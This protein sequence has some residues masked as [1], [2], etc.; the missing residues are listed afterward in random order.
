MP[1]N[2]VRPLIPIFFLLSMGCASAPHSEKGPPIRVAIQLTPLKVEEIPLEQYVLGVLSGEV[3]ADWPVE[4]LKAQA[5]ASRTYAL[6]RKERPKG[7][8]GG[9]MYDVESTVQAQVFD[10][11]RKY[12]PNFENAVEETQGETL[13]YEG[14][15]IPAFFHS[16]CGGI[17]ERADAVWAEEFPPPLNQIHEDPYCKDSPRYRWSYETDPQ[18]LRGEI[19]VLERSETGRVDLLLLTSE[20]EDQELTGNQLREKVGYDKIKSTLF[21]VD[22]TG[23][24][25]VF[26]GLGAGHGVGLCQWGAK[27]MAEQGYGYREILGFYYPGAEI[28]HSP[29]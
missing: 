19:Q 6:Y 25:P 8:E 13:R 5:V 26:T 12:P 11:R 15:V 17:G 2:P 9:Q 27:G 24:R 1:R 14:K 4:A 18:E 7:S 29:L 21:D 23:V 16:T 10:K 20:G 3:H 28:G 22:T